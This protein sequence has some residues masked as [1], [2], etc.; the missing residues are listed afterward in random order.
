MDLPNFDFLDAKLLASLGALLL[1]W[2]QWS[3]DILPTD[4][5]KVIKLFSIVSAV[6]F[7]VLIYFGAQGNLYAK[8]ALYAIV[9][10]SAS[11]LG[12]QVLTIPKA[13]GKKTPTTPEIIIEQISPKGVPPTK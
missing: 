12:Y 13:N 8:L 10:A 11:G 4:N 3:K 9:A 2:I 5:A 1:I 6:V 7:S